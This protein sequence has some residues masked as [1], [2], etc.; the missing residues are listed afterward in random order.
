MFSAELER[1]SFSLDQLAPEPLAGGFG[2]QGL[3]PT[4]AWHS[5]VQTD[6]VEDNHFWYPSDLDGTEHGSDFD[7]FSGP[8]NDMSP[9]S[10]IQTEPNNNDAPSETVWRCLAC[11][12]KRWTAVGTAWRCDVC[13]GG[14]FYRCDRPTKQINEAGTWM[15]VPHAGS[16]SSTSTSSRRRRR[17]RNQPAGNDS[18]SGPSDSVGS[19]EWAESENPTVDPVVDPSAP[20]QDPQTISKQLHHR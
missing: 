13:S 2:C 20:G 3:M 16:P 5:A 8:L 1:S 11:D 15:F 10:P 4:R 9:A 12:S 14:S 17:R 18:P 6:D 7:L 19:G